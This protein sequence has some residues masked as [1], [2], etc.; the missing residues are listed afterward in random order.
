MWAWLIKQAFTPTK[1]HTHRERRSDNL[2]GD[3]DALCELY[4]AKPRGDIAEPPRC[5]A[6]V[7]AYLDL[8]GELEM[9][10]GGRG[11]SRIQESNNVV[12]L[13]RTLLSS[14]PHFIILQAYGSLLVR[15]VFML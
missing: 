1:A 8:A 3:V 15:K 9:L 4:R 10:T 6:S 12:F 5:A 14:L 7:S 11:V 2:S 13:N